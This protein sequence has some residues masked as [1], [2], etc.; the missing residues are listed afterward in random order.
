MAAAASGE[1]D[2]PDEDDE[3]YLAPEDRMDF[4]MTPEETVRRAAWNK[5]LRCRIDYGIHKVPYAYV[6]AKVAVYVGKNVSATARS[7]LEKDGWLIMEFDDSQ[8]TDGKKEADEIYAA[9]KSRLPKKK[10]KT[11]KK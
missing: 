4:T 8:V 9:V 3:Y 6:N 10:R 11:K 1:D 5:R 2:E 7:S